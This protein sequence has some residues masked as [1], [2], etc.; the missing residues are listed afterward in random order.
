MKT[1]EAKQLI[2]QWADQCDHWKQ[3]CESAKSVKTR[4]MAAGAHHAIL[5]CMNDLIFKYPS[6]AKA[7]EKTEGSPIE[8]YH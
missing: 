5:D 8:D 2:A 6:I 7:I 1:K 3:V 4:S